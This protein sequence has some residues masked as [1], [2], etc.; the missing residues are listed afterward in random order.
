MKSVMVWALVAV[1]SSLW[2]V[3]SARDQALA[4]GPD[5]WVGGDLELSHFPRAA[6]DDERWFAA[7]YVTYFFW[8]PEACGFSDS[9][10]WQGCQALD[11]FGGGYFWS[12]HPVDI[13]AIDVDNFM[14]VW[15]IT[16][17][18]PPEETLI[19]GRR[20]SAHAVLLTDPFDVASSEVDHPRDPRVV[21][22]PSSRVIVIWVD[23][24]SEGTDDSGSSIQG[25]FFTTDGSP[26][27][28]RFQVNTT[29]LG[30]QTVPDVAAAP[31]GRFVVTW[32]SESSTGSDDS[33]TSIQLRRFDAEGNPLGSDQ[34]V[35]TFVSSDQRNARVACAGN[36]SFVVV[37]DS[38]GSSGNDD[39]S[40]SV[41]ARI[42]DAEGAPLGPDFQVNSSI[43]GTQ[44]EP[45]VGTM[46]AGGFEVVWADEDSLENIQR[47][48]F[49]SGGGKI[50]S[51][52]LVNTT[53]GSSLADPD[54]AMTPEGDFVAVWKDYL[55]GL[56]GRIFRQ[57]LL[58][59]GF[60]SGD[61]S[62]WSATVP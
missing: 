20:M 51:Q 42:F 56:R 44:A 41:Q 33:G 14:A 60:E 18:G 32:E 19:R 16:S 48:A 25:R 8:W 28:P 10:V 7:T 43:E 27:G 6:I 61:T 11:D 29:V 15:E 35:N 30:N 21:A 53:A 40:L 24:S 47:Q 13:A 57:P 4:V 58:A 26:L 45:A 23:D 36:G 9:G 62:A 46:G 17:P 34:Q 37:W 12:Q 1:G 3:P 52:S 39:S 31:D 5:F 38:D 50:G 2:A 49:D 54:I 22:L 55:F 59:D